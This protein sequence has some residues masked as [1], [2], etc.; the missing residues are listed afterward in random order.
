MILEIDLAE[1]LQNPEKAKEVIKKVQGVIDELTMASTE[2]IAMAKKANALA[3]EYE[4]LNDALTQSTLD[5]SA[6]IKAIH[7]LLGRKVDLFQGDAELLVLMNELAQFVMSSGAI[8]AGVISH[9]Q[10]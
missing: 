4:S 8:K 5:L 1:G 2:A 7:T 6:T 10:N 3:E 9:G